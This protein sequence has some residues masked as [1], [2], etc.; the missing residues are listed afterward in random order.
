RRSSDLAL[1]TLAVAVVVVRQRRPAAAIERQPA[2]LIVPLELTRVESAFA[3][4]SLQGS[5]AHQGL[6]RGIKKGRIRNGAPWVKRGVVEERR[7]DVPGGSVS[8]SKPG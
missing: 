7:R 4:L 8:R 1:L 5:F 2:D 6:R 3:Q